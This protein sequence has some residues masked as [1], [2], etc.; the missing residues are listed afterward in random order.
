MGP[1]ISAHL[2]AGYES[3]STVYELAEVF[4]IDRRTASAILHRHD[5]AMRRRGCTVPG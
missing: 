2:I 3:G 4:G 1:G 5:V